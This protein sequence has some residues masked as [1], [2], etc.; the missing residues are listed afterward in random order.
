MRTLL[1]EDVARDMY[2]TVFASLPRRDQRRRAEEYVQGLLRTPGRKSFRSIA[3]HTGGD[4][5]AEQRLHHLVTGS[6]WD[7]RP[8]RTALVEWLAATNPLSAWVVQPM[9]LPRNGERPCGTPR[10]RQSF[11]VWFVAPR[12][13]TPVAWRLYLPDDDTVPE[14]TYEDAV[15]AAVLEAT[16]SAPTPKR[17]VVLDVGGIDTPTALTHLPLAELPTIARTRPAT[18][19]RMADPALPG[20]GAGTRTARETLAAVTSLRRPVEW[21][22]GAPAPSVSLAAAVPVT[23]PARRPALLLGEW[24]DPRKPPA[25]FWV[26]NMRLPAPVLLRLTKHTDRVTRTAVTRARQTG[27]RDFAGR[28]LT[29]W[30]RHLTLASVACAVAAFPPPGT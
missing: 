19:V 18:P 16:G 22:D 30:H 6:T 25:N 13:V 9:P 10:C 7:W 17:P 24:P 4:S 11:G 20:Y 28:S 2:A 26:T 21:H 1:H 29:G 23:T 15:T 8:V 12:A 27:L 5:A 3:Q 14:E